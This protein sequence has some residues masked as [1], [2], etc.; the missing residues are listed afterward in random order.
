MDPKS[1]SYTDETVLGICLSDLDA[2]G[3]CVVGSKKLRRYGLEA[4]L[5]GIEGNAHIE[6]DRGLESLLP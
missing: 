1:S 2:A 6:H 5:E 3:T 4:K